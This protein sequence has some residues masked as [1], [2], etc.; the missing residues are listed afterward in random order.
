MLST[1][2]SQVVIVGSS[3]YKDLR[4]NDVPSV[5][6]SAV[7]LARALVSFCGVHQESI[8]LLID[9]QSPREIGDAVANSSEQASEVLMFYYIGHGLISPR[10]DLYLAD[11]NTDS[12]LAWLPN[13]AIRYTAIREIFQD[14]VAR[15]MVVILDCCFAGRA[16]TTLSDSED[17]SALAGIGGACVIAASARNELALAPSRISYT[18]FTGE[19]I[20]YLTHGSP[21][22]PPSL[23]LRSAFRHLAIQLPAKGFPRPNRQVSGDADQLVLGP[24]TSIVR[25]FQIAEKSARRPTVDDWSKIYLD[26]ND[27]R[28]IQV[29]DLARELSLSSDQILSRLQDMGEFV[30][31]SSSFLSLHIA[32]RLRNDISAARQAPSRSRPCPCGSNRPYKNC[33]GSPRAARE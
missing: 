11:A 17:I 30:K 12:R 18:A 14:S 26:S 32:N 20:N 9:P 16:I 22:D 25:G 29:D 7:G 10:G 24:N 13:S 19:L 8:T 2:G 28:E 27:R 31:S 15:T 6:R 1:A 33:H 5:R 4:L 3:Q 23:T 21:N